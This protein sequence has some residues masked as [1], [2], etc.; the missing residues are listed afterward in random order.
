VSQ[1]IAGPEE[2]A[3]YVGDGPVL[4]DDRPR[5]EY[6]LSLP[7]DGGPPDLT[8]VSGDVWRHVRD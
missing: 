7:R 3:A 8:G 1:Y 4:T 2:L 6:F 5:V